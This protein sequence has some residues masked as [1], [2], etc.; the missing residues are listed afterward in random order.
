MIF[1]PHQASSEDAIKLG[2]ETIEDLKERQVDKV[3]EKF[4][5]VPGGIL[6]RR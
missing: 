2:E 1:L 5:K 6:H 4:E 3:P